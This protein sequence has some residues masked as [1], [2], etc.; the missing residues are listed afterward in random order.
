MGIL[1][2]PVV[3][4]IFQSYHEFFSRPL[5]GWAV[6]VFPQVFGLVDAAYPFATGLLQLLI[7]GTIALIRPRLGFGDARNPDLY[8]SLTVIT[9]VS[10]CLFSPILLSS[11]GHAGAFKKMG[12]VV[13]TITPISEEIL[14]RGFLH[15]LLLQIFHA[16]QDSSW[17]KILPP[18]VFGGLWFSLWHLVPSAISDYGWEVVGPQ[19][20]ITFFAGVLFSGLR[21]WTGSIWLGI[22]IHAAGNFLA[23]FL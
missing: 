3:W 8:Q 14:F 22:P 6:E 18:L 1:S 10:I 17:K 16:A 19:L 12:V 21:H 4:G 23:G 7:V 13:W 20:V 2:L 15:S 5:V 11:S 9:L